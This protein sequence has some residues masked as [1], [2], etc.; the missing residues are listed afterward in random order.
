MGKN[1]KFRV[2]NGD[3]TI[4]VDSMELGTTIYH[5]LEF[6]ALKGGKNF[7]SLEDLQDIA[8]NS[9]D[10]FFYQLSMDIAIA[11]EKIKEEDVRVWIY[12][13]EGGLFSYF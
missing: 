12:R 3:S 4:W 9:G 8:T 2:K 13:A 10:P 1:V 7:I 11:C 5:Q 6:A